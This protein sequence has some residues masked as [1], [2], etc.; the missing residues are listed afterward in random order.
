MRGRIRHPLFQTG[1]THGFFINFIIL[2]F[3]IVGA[4]IPVNTIAAEELNLGA[5]G[6]S[7]SKEIKRYA[8]LMNYLKSMGVPA[9]KVLTAKTTGQMIELLNTGKVHFIMETP[10]GALEMMDKAGVVPILIRERDGVIEYNSVLF[11]RKDS[12]IKVFSDLTGKVVAFEDADSTSSYV[13][14][15]VLLER[16]GLTLKQSNQPEDGVVSYYFSKDDDNTL[17]QVKAGDK[18]H[19]GG[20]SKSKV[21]KNPDFRMLSPESD[22]VPRGVVLVSKDLSPDKLTRVLLDMKNDPAAAGILK[23]IKTPTGFSKFK[24]DPSVIM[25]TTIRNTLGL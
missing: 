25:N 3:F 22:Y 17:A 12:P 7:P 11:V 1:I 23:G 15:K 21:Q 16:A 4:L 5:I 13:M 10:Y 14:P 8:P 9:G 24:G 2:A 20:I 19:A 18:A 6:S